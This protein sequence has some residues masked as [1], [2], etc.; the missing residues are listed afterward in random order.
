MDTGVIGASTDPVLSTRS[1][2]LGLQPQ[3]KK[4]IAD[5]TSRKTFSVRS[6][7]FISC[8]IM[9]AYPSPF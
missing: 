3:V 2:A 4:T 9:M 5:P 8:L 7:N 6:L 1:F